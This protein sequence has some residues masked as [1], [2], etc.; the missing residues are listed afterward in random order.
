MIRR[1]DAGDVV[2]LA[3]VDGNVVGVPFALDGSL[4]FSPLVASVFNFFNGFIL[5]IEYE[6]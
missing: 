6:R 4:L 2:I 1:L 3:C 5:F